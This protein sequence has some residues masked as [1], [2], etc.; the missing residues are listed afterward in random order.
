MLTFLRCLMQRTPFTGM[1]SHNEAKCEHWIWTCN[2]MCVMKRHAATVHRKR[3]H[4]WFLLAARAHISIDTKRQLLREDLKSSDKSC[5]KIC[6]TEAVTVFTFGLRTFGT[7]GNDYNI[8]IIAHPTNVLS[9]ERCDSCFFTL[10]L[11]VYSVNPGVYYGL[12]ICGNFLIWPMFNDGFTVNAN[13]WSHGVARCGRWEH[14]ARTVCSLRWQLRA[15]SV[16]RRSGV[17]GWRRPKLRP[18]HIGTT[19]RLQSA[20]QR[21]QWGKRLRKFC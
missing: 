16:K 3:L 11:G 12:L 21:W 19:C 7:M 18:P 4:H 14:R 9:S 8:D 6:G 17:A 20:A 10:I 5:Q 2:D 15:A 1:I 13:L